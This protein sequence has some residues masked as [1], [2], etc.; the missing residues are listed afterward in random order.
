MDFISSDNLEFGRF[1]KIESL[2]SSHY[3]RQHLDIK[4][5]L[6]HYLDL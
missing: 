3:I 6:S 2:K 4:T 1:I 5:A